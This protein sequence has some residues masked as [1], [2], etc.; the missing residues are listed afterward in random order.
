MNQPLKPGAAVKFKNPADADEA[1]VVFV[2]IEDRSP[3]VL[4]CDVASPMKIKPQFSYLAA[5]LC[6]ADPADIAAA[7]LS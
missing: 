3:R 4:V 1:S 7:G 5:D 6:P 2:V